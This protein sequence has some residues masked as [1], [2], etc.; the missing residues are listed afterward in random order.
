MSRILT[1]LVL[2]ATALSG[3]TRDLVGTW[4]NAD[5]NPRGITRVQVT[6]SDG[7]F[8]VQAWGACSPQDCD[9][10]RVRARPFS[11]SVSTS[12]EADAHT[13]SA[14]FR[15][16]FNRT[17]LV[18]ASGG[19]GEL[20]V[21]LM[22]TFTDQ[23]NRS[24]YASSERFRR[25][26]R[27]GVRPQLKVA[28]PLRV[29]G[30]LAAATGP[31]DPDVEVILHPDGTVEKVYPDGKREIIGESSKRTIFPDGREQMQLNQNAPPG[32]PPPV[33]ANQE[34]LA[35]LEG[36]NQ[37]LLWIIISL[38]SQTMADE[39]VAQYEAGMDVFDRM[40]K[41]TWLIGQLASQ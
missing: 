24:S 39:Y 37:S 16:D 41:R 33:P 6:H 28:Q 36:H 13:L 40:R 12:P 3:A 34:H 4:V 38:T 18:L 11:G 7:Q 1:L 31:S 32:S 14:S 10:G 22:T 25:R 2:A 27:T 8:F 17:Q 29:V 20:R 19:N 35:W 30:G 21:E 5:A 26:T 23:S 15:T 9:W